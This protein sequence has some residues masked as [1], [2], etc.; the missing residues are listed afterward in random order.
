[1]PATAFGLP[2]LDFRRPSDPELG[3]TMATTSPGEG[4]RGGS[5]ASAIASVFLGPWTA[6]FAKRGSVFWPHFWA[7]A[8]DSLQ[9]G[10]D[11]GATWRTPF[12]FLGDFFLNSLA[13]LCAA[14]RSD[15]CLGSSFRPGRA[16]S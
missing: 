3:P 1:M 8:W 12:F 14:L 2:D 7:R 13:S 6:G 16:W 9:G 10:V 15:C 4:S 5:E 11:S